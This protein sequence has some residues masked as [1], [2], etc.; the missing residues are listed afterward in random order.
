MLDSLYIAHGYWQP[1]CTASRWCPLLHDVKYA[2][3][4]QQHKSSINAMTW[5]SSVLTSLILLAVFMGQLSDTNFKMST[6]TVVVQLQTN[7]SNI[8]RHID[9]K[10]KKSKIHFKLAGV[11]YCVNSSFQLELI[12]I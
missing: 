8:T 9:K 11:R 12:N 1:V 4:S 6:E 10:P 2:Q 7:P 3:R 5:R